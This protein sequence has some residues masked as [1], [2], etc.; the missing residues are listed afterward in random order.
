MELIDNRANQVELIDNRASQVAP[1]GHAVTLVLLQ[2]VD[3]FRI[4]PFFGVFDVMLS[5]AVVKGRH[6][7][8]FR[9]P[10]W[11]WYYQEES[12]EQI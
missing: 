7:C 4:N 5:S 11:L 10:N 2:V 12:G 3:K 1:I 6:C 8:V 9:A